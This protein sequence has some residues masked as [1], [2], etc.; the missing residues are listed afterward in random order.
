MNLLLFLLPFVAA[1]S[2]D[3]VPDKLEKIGIIGLMGVAIWVQYRENRAKEAHNLKMAES[4]TSTL[5]V[6]ESM[7][8]AL[9]R[10]SKK[11][12]GCPQ[13]RDSLTNST[14]K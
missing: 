3:L 4:L 1:Q 11:I 2:V 13:W 10:L 7:T 6:I 14:E 8:E 9:E 12:E 5:A